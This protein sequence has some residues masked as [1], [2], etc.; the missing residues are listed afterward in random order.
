MGM[1][2]PVMQQA[3]NHHIPPGFQ[4]PPVFTGAARAMDAMRQA[5]AERDEA[6]RRLTCKAPAC[7]PG[8]FEMVHQAGDAR[9]VCHLEF[10][11]GDDGAPERGMPTHQP[12]KPYCTLIAAYVGAGEVSEVLRLDLVEQI[13]ADGLAWVTDQE[14]MA[15]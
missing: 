13:E 8:L 2:H 11:P 4:S 6:I 1:L 3:L 15:A 9:I 5:L 14:R 10:E 7:P 12:V